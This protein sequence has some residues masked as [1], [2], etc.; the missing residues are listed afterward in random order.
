MKYQ[1]GD[2]VKYDCGD[3]VFFGSITA[4]IQNSIN[5]CY[6]ITV[7]RIVKKNCKFSITPFEFELLPGEELTAGNS[8]IHATVPSVI[9]PEPSSHPEQIPVQPATKKPS[10]KPLPIP[11]PKFQPEEQLPKELQPKVLQPKVLQP[12][13][14]QPKVLQPKELQPKKLQPK[15]LQPKKLQPKELQPEELQPEEQIPVESH[16]E[17]QLPE[18]PRQEE[19]KSD[20]MEDFQ[21]PPT[22]LKIKKTDAWYKNFHLFMNGIRNNTIYSWMNKNRKAFINNL[23]SEEKRNMLLKINFPFKLTERRQKPVDVQLQNKSDQSNNLW[24]LKIKQWKSGKFEAL[25]SWRQ[26]C[27][28]LY[29]NGKL[30]PTKIEQLKEIGILN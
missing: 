2:Q 14:L 16:P 19:P 9:T 6:R 28:R 3:W 26:K 1:I 20:M 15:E 4:V 8:Y 12:K 22:P 11:K 23:L 17:K 18:E 7:N 25:K 24:E 30:S 29:V 21:T 10:K 5:P 27:V 13:V